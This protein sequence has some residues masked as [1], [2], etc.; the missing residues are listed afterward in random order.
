[1]RIVL[2]LMF[3][4][5]AGC[6][7]DEDLAPEACSSPEPVTL[8][9]GMSSEVT[10]C[11]ADPE[12]ERLTFS[13]M[14]SSD[15]VATAEISDKVVTVMGQTAGEATITV[16]A[17]DPGGQSADI[18][19]MVTVTAPN[20]PE[21]L[22]ADSF[23][24]LVSGW[25]ASDVTESGIED[26]RL[27]IATDDK[28]KIATFSH[29]VDPAESPIIRARVENNTD[30]FWPTL[31]IHSKITIIAVVFGADIGRMSDDPTLESNWIGMFW[32][33]NTEGWLLLDYGQHAA[34]GGAGTV[35]DIELEISETEIHVRVDNTTIARGDR[36]SVIPNTIQRVGIGGAWPDDK[37]ATTASRVYFDWVEVIAK[38]TG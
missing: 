14:S 4:L 5:L 37:T 1:M 33:A 29:V 30:D 6:G 3:L 34:I 24:V 2:A 23:A 7:M 22:L 12:G 38:P 35:M 19:F 10:T 16:T 27:W 17:L 13:V 21:M 15:A 25:Q 9:A 11:F 32:D 26:G 18:G 20:E 31:L 8:E 28:S 36:P